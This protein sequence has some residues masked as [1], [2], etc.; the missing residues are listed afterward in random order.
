MFGG[1]Q[2]IKVPL[3]V[4]VGMAAL[5]GERRQIVVTA[6]ISS[7]QPAITLMR[8]PFITPAV[9]TMVGTQ[10]VPGLW[11][12]ASKTDPLANPGCGKLVTAMAGCL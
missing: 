2:F 6:F 1:S 8:L 7:V 9:A 5:P 3:P 10:M 12:S 4:G 11:V